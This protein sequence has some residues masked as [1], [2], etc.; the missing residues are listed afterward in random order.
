M[1]DDVTTVELEDVLVAVPLAGLPPCCCCLA[2]PRGKM[3]RLTA[4]PPVSIPTGFLLIPLGTP[5]FGD[6]MITTSAALLSFTVADEGEA[7]PPFTVA[8]PPGDAL[9][10]APVAGTDTIFTLPLWDTLLSASLMALFE[11]VRIFFGVSLPSWSVAASFSLS[12]SF[13][14]TPPSSDEPS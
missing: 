6:F 1:A 14:L 11:S 7:V 10:L 5:S 3:P 12:S 8:D 9:M 2:S 13:R 4:V